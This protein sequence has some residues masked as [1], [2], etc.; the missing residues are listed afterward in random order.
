MTRALCIPLPRGKE[1][2]LKARV[3]CREMIWIEGIS[4]KVPDGFVVFLDYDCAPIQSVVEDVERLQDYF[5]LGPAYIFQTWSRGFHVIVPEVY[6][7]DQVYKILSASNADPS[8][9]NAYKYNPFRTW[10]LRVGLKGEKQPPQ[11]LAML[12][13]PYAN[14]LKSLG[15][16]NHLAFRGVPEDDLLRE[17]HNGHDGVI[18]SYYRTKHW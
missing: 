18:S 10:V 2:I 17:P 5:E 8:H 1:L 6:T 3:N 14:N 12:V 7:L 15:H 13:S 11:Y 16:L 9:A 4:A